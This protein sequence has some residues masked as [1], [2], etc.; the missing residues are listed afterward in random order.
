MLAEFTDISLIGVLMNQWSEQSRSIDGE[1]LP[2]LFDGDVA[3]IGGGAAG[4]AAAT[5]ASEKGLETV[6]IE[7]YG[8]TGGAA[9]AG[10]SG[11]VCGLY[12]GG[13]SPTT[14]PVDQ[15]VFGFAEKFRHRLGELGGVTNAQ[16][17][18]HT[19]T[20]T[21]DPLVWR[22]AG[23]SFLTS[24]GVRILFHTQVIGTI[25]E[26]NDVKGVIVSSKAGFA[27]I[28]A[29]RIIDASGDATV[30]ARGGFET[31]VGDNGV[32]Q[33]P[34]MIFRIGNVD[35]K[36]FIDYWGPDT[37]S[38]P[39]VVQL[40]ESAENEHGY[41]LPRKKIWIFETTRAGELLINA[42]R[43][44][45]PDGRPLDPL[46]PEDHTYAE[47]H[48]REQVEEYARFLK[49][50]IPG[51]E[52]SFVVDTGVEAGIRQTR[53]IEAL[54]KLKNDDVVDMRKFEDGIARSAWP[55]ELHSASAP[56]LHWLIDDFYEIPFRTMV[57]VTA[58]NIIVAGRCISAEHEALAS[59]RVTAQCFELGQAAALATLESIKTGTAF[60]ELD[61]ALIRESMIANGSIL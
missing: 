24:S 23:D 8:F 9:V 53:S 61:G 38:P 5:V 1:D 12:A 44:S 31:Y 43:L 33:N 21:H 50:F 26:G 22:R 37:I 34:T 6:L 60:R 55:I 39:K 40:L 4:V 3:V 59:A 10:L 2:V 41:K 14:E 42:T 13:D 30:V 49:S 25:A 57:P 32:V 46:D 35:T 58:N 19:M 56:K 16:V 20:V 17:Y 7:G 54:Q 28:R 29:R 27:Q 18:G 48:G 36:A 45:G 11:T 47:I 51:C 15:I 52:K